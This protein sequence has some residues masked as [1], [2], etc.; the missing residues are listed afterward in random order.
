MSKY[1]LV[2]DEKIGEQELYF[3]T[4]GEFSSDQ[5]KAKRMSFD[6]SEIENIRLQLI[7]IKNWIR[8]ADPGS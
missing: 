2:M 8:S 6:E 1:I 7:G 4:N 5:S 3:V